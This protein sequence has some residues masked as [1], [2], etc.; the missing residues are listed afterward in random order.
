MNETEFLDLLRYYFRNA[1][2]EEVN[3]ILA[4]YESHFEEGKKRGL[5]EEEIAKELGSPK[6]IYNSFQSE[7]VVE[8]KSK[9][10]SPI[11]D[12]AQKIAKDAQVQAEKAWSEISPKLPA[13]AEATARVTSRFLTAAG[14][15][16]G[17]IILAATGLIIGLLTMNFTPFHGAPPLPQF[18]PLTLIS[19]GSFS[20]FTALSIYLITQESSKTIRRSFEKTDD[21][22]DSDRS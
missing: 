13:A 15:I 2:A 11:R 6:D 3:E 17:V 5:S 9:V 16:I 1:K 10:S 21:G 4:D 8:E 12:T 18:S 7:G 14:I 22:K 20:I 19:I